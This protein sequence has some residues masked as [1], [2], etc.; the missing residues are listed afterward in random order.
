MI[1][2]KFLAAALFTL[3]ITTLTNAQ[4][5]GTRTTR[6]ARRAPAAAAAAPGVRLTA[7]DMLLIVS[8]LDLPPQIISKLA[9]DAAERKQFAQEIR[10]MVAAAEEAKALG[11][12][13]RPELKLQIELARS[14]VIAQAYIKQ[15]QQAGVTDPAQVV[16]QAEI[17][18]LLAEPAQQ[19]QLAAFLEDYRKNGPGRGAALS[20]EQ[21]KQIAQHY[22]G[23]IAAMRKGTTA[24]LAAQRS[25]QLAVMLQQDK[26]LAGA[27]SRDMAARHKATEAELDAYIAAHPEYD[28]KVSRAKIEGLLGRVRAGEDFAKLAN[29][30][31]EDPSGKGTGGDLGW[32]GRGMMVKPFEEAAFTL[33]AGEVSG[34]VETQFGYHIV[35]VDERRTQGAAEE[36]HARHI[37]I[38]FNAAPRTPGTPPLSP[39]DQA[40]AAVG[41]EKLERLFNE[42][43]VRRN[44]QVAENYSVTPD[45]QGAAPAKPAS[46]AGT[47]AKPAAK[48][49]VKPATPARRAPARRR[50]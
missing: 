31:T 50:N 11:Y 16:S 46:S 43:A 28:T 30:F 5:K 39:R 40:R 8:S 36:V 29:E 33:K 25:T 45:T 34:V 10:Q 15:R 17:D 26:L 47:P 4:T 27:Y 7:E 13:A 2:R 24:G 42:I 32:F 44:V 41:E 18:A 37:L 12:A 48:P 14:Y 19:Q 23:V 1:L 38:K 49:P 20:E 21:R 9:T 6:A 22:G 35:K 3:V